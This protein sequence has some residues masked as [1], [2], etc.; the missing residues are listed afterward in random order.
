[1]RARDIATHATGPDSIAVVTLDLQLYDMAMKLWMEREDIKKQFLF[2]PGELHIVFWSLAALGKYVEGSGID[3]AWVEAGL[4]SPTTV[5]QILNGKHVYRAIEAHTVTL[6][7]L[8]SLYF[9]NFLQLQPDEEVFLK[10]TSASLGEAYQEDINLDPESRHNL[11]DAVTKTIEMFQSRDIFK[12]IEQSEGTANKIQRFIS[13]YTKQFETI[14]Q[15]VRATRQRDILLHMQSLEAL[16]KYFFAHDHLNYAR[17]LP[18]YIST[19]QETEKQHPEIW[20]EFVKGNFCVTKG[21]V[22]FTSI[23]P[24]HGIEQENRELKVVGGIVG[25][26][27]NEKSLDKYFLI[28]PE[29]SNLQREFE[30]TYYTGNNEKRTQHHELTGGKLSRVTQNAIKLSAVFHHHGNPFESADEDE[31]YNLLT[32]SVMNETVANDILRRDEIGQQMFEVF[33]TERLTEGKLS[34]WD[35]IT[36]KKLGTYKTANA[37]T[38]IK[39]GDSIIKIKEERGLLQRFIVISRSR[40]ELD[41]KECIGTYEFGVIPRSL[42]ASDGSLLLAYDKASILHHLE[43]LSSNSQQVEADRNKATE[44]EPSI[45]QSI[46]AST[47][48]SSSYSSR[49][50]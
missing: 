6:L 4:Y 12:K 16:I 15:F 28:A 49:T 9:R 14:L 50:Y 29:L 31:I 8:Y 17:L 48:T 7:A 13:N 35:K 36:K 18:L 26:T 11:S 3:Q 22:G 45:N 24:D 30:N 5:T 37:S 42:F 32:K 2:R 20:A 33:V 43:N 38:E 25:I 34:V 27:Q 21:V 41:L 46:S 19:M 40:P 47:T 44:S 39:V 10:E 23:G 1:M